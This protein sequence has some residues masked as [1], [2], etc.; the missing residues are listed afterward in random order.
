MSTTDYNG[1]A[2]LEIMECAERAVS[3]V[4]GQLVRE[5]HQAPTTEL[6]IEIDK[7]RDARKW[8]I[9]EMNRYPRHPAVNA[10]IK[11]ARPIDW[12]QLFMEWPHVANS[13]NSKIAYTQNEDKGQ[14]DIQ[15]AT[16]VGKYLTRHFR[17]PDH[18]IRDLVSRYGSGAQYKFVHTTADMIDH[19]HKGPASCMVWRDDRGVRCDDGVQRHPYETY[20]PKHGWHMAVRVEGDVTLGRALCMTSPYNNGRKY[21]VRTYSRDANNAG[22]SQ[23]DNGMESWL[24]DQGYSKLDGWLDGEKLAYYPADNGF[25]APF[26]DGESSQKHVSVHNDEEEHWL[27]IDCDGSYICDNTGGYPTDESGDYFDCEDC[28]DRTADDDGYWAGEHED[29]HI[30]SSCC[31]NDFTHAISRR[32]NHYY[33]RSDETVYV[34]S[35]RESYHERYLSDNGIVEL[36]NGEYEHHEEAVEINGEWYHIDDED[37]CRTEDTDEFLLRDDGCWQCTHSGNWY[38]DSIDFVEV[39]GEKFHPK[40]CPDPDDAEIDEDEGMPTML[41][42]EMLDKVLTIWDYS[43]YA[44]RVK[45]SLTYTLDGKMLLAERTFTLEFI[46]GIDNKAFTK[47]IRNELST[48][49]MAKANEIAN[50]YLA[51]T[52]TQGE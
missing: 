50:A 16:S 24:R 21:F 32:G 44:D 42:M 19:L 6:C 4:D 2:M 37:I 15:T 40:Y 5:W 52:E 14:R 22:Y 23:T 38:T 43:C 25:L 39:D 26:L 18:I 41:T 9:R 47:L 7:K 1:T 29:Y 51:S 10:A 20:D 12:Q 45:I 8:I 31:D 33:I 48:E 34:D 27:M 28:G 49:L 46:S 30:C 11:E 3:R 17:L 13:D 35:Q 36:R